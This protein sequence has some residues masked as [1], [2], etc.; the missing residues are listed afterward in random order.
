M[1]LGSFCCDGAIST[2]G[3]QV[4]MLIPFKAYFEVAFVNE[5]KNKILQQT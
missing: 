5:M 1:P 4:S 2:I 3:K